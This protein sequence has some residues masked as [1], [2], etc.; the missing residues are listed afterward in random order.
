MSGRFVLFCRHISISIVYML[1]VLCNVLITIQ[2]CTEGE[3]CPHEA[4][5]IVHDHTKADE[6]SQ[7]TM[8]LILVTNS[9]SITYQWR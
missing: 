4:L 5:K 9:T 1:I 6:T 8:L 2:C 7:H 3:A